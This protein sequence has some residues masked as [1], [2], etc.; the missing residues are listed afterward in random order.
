MLA[1]GAKG[2]LRGGD[3][4][5]VWVRSISGEEYE[6]AAAELPGSR[7]SNRITIHIARSVRFPPVVDELSRRLL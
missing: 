4:K 2:G 1:A 6:G 7:P 3:S 5:S